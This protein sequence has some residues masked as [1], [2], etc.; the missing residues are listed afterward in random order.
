[1][2]QNELN[3]IYMM[4]EAGLEM[5]K[6]KDV[7]DCVCNVIEVCK[8][9]ELVDEIESTTSWKKKEAE[10]LEFGKAMENEWWRLTNPFK[11]L[12]KAQLGRSFLRTIK[13]ALNEL[14]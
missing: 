10:L 3:A 8:E 4:A 7:V 2:T 12:S 11:W 13:R 14:R 6:K 9:K 5:N 1:M